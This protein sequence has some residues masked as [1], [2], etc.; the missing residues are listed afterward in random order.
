MN[1]GSWSKADALSRVTKMSYDRTWARRIYGEYAKLC[2]RTQ[3]INACI[4]QLSK[5][6]GDVGTP[7]SSVVGWIISNI[8]KKDRP[9]VW[10]MYKRL[11]KR[12][13][14]DKE[15]LAEVVLRFHRDVNG[16]YWKTRQL[17][18]PF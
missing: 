6:A 5:D 14:L 1:T 17:E 7:I 2:P 10:P 8:Q 16:D 15:L 13:P 4:V 12:S 9:S 11:C 3:Q 18:L